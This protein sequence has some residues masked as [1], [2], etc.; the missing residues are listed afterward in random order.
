MI[1]FCSTSIVVWLAVCGGYVVQ[2]E[3]KNVDKSKWRDPHEIRP[4]VLA[5]Y[6]AFTV[7]VDWVNGCPSTNLSLAGF[8]RAAP[9]TVDWQYDSFNNRSTLYDLI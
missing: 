7:I 6:P 8:S 4:D 3:T 9:S 2:G 5:K 1:H